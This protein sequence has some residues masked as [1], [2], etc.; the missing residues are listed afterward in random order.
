[1]Y[2]A[3][4]TIEVEAE[5]LMSVKHITGLIDARLNNSCMKNIKTCNLEVTYEKD[6]EYVDHDEREIEV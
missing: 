4:I 3:T 2:K 6:G 5:D 1:M